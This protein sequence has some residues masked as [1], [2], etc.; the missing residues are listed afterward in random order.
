MSKTTICNWLPSQVSELILK[1]Y[2][3]QGFLPAQEEIGWRAHQGDDV[4]R[5]GE[6]EVMVFQD[7]LLRGFSPPRPF[8]TF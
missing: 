5:L 6:G 3:A 4:P 1:D 7:R 8:G 2:Q